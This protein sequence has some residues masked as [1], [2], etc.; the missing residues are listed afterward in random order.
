M[1]FEVR[2]NGE[3]VWGTDDRVVRISGQSARGELF[4]SGIAPTD[5]VVDFFVEFAVSPGVPRLDEIEDA[6]QAAIR[7]VPEG[8]PTGTAP[9]EPAADANKPG[10][11]SEDLSGSA[12]AEAEVEEED[13]DTGTA[14]PEFNLS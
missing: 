14:K 5:G 8:T 4:A 7:E 10:Q 2:V 6:K 12:S 3:K 9:Y 1:A 13:D 11:T